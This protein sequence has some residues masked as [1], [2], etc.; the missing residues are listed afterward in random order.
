MKDPKSESGSRIARCGVNSTTVA[1]AAGLP[2]RPPGK[3]NKRHRSDWQ[4]ELLTQEEVAALLQ[5]TVRT[6]ERWQ[7]EGVL[8]HLRLGHTVRFYWPA[9]VNHL[10]T[11]FTVCRGR[12]VAAPP[13]LR[14]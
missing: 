14:P 9:V 11:H 8:P 5:V 2:V 10:L 13:A 12:A 3:V 1:S 6:V 4:E 7:Q